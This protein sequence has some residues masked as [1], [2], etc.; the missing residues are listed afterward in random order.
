MP[1]ILH[2]VAC[3]D[4]TGICAISL[5]GGVRRQISRFGGGPAWS[6][7]GKQIAFMKGDAELWLADAGDGGLKRVAGVEEP[8]GLQ[9]RSVGYDIPPRWSPD[10]RLLWFSLTHTEARVPDPARIAHL[11]QELTRTEYPES[12]HDDMIRVSLEASQWTHTKYIGIIDFAMRQG[13]SLPADWTE[14]AW[15]P[16]VD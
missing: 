3:A 9:E 13:W 15:S 12:E 4:P 14:A 16:V 11:R 10:G 7:D 5:T 1:P 6:P 8:A 2:E